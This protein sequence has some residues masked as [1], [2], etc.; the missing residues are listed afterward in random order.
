MLEALGCAVIDCDLLA[1]E[2]VR[3]G[4]PVL[5]KL[6]ERFGQDIIC[7]GGNLDRNLLA[8]RAFESLKARRDLNFI[9][10]PAITDL[11]EQ[12]IKALQGFKAIALDAAALLESELTALCGHIL[13]IT[14]P[15]NLRLQRILAR[16]AITEE[17][18][19]RR[20]EAQRQVDYRPPP[21]LGHTIIDTS[22]GEAAL[23][24]EIEKAFR[25]V[26]GDTRAAD[27]GAAPAAV[28]PGA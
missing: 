3:P 17:Q 7:K 14:A 2:I 23:R 9:T 26:V 19:R 13:I 12:R 20:I 15:E 6:A 1:R 28:P 11:A 8:Q 25:A 18:A 16:D 5:L 24:H 27:G 21:G 22:E 10:H 4:S